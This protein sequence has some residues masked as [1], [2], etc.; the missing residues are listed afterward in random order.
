ML[1]VLQSP[2]DNEDARAELERRALSFVRTDWVGRL[3]RRLGVESCSIGD[4]RKS[5][6]VLRTAE[7]IEASLGKPDAIVDFGAYHSE[8]TGILSRIGYANL[9]AVDLNPR[10]RAGPYPDRIHYSVCDFLHSGFKDASF[11]AITS[12]SAIEH[13]H[14]VARLL[15]EVSRVLKPGGWFI[16]STDYWPEK[17]DTRGVRVFGMDWTIFSAAEMQA[18]FDGAQRRGLTPHGS[19][20]FDATTPSIHF[21][22]RDYTFAWFALRKSA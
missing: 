13:G 1:R 6:D 11:S 10:L 2:R 21:A 4:A 18:F 8:I 3:G 17:L 5:W 12:I 16:G 9:H 14:S 15:D 19:L 22:G 20:E 7:L